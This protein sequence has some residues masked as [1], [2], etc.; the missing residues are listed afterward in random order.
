[1]ST[2]NERQLLYCEFCGKECYSRNSLL[3]HQRRCRYNPNQLVS[4]GAF[5][6]GATAWNKGLTK[7]TD[8][9]VAAHSE[10]V[11]QTK[12][13]KP[14]VNCG[15]AS[16]PEKEFERRAKIAAYAKTR[17]LGGL[18]PK[19]GRGKKGW[20]KGYFCDS[21]YELVFVIYNIDNNIFFKRC[22]RSYSYTVDNKEYRY[23]PDF[24]LADGS[25]VEIKGYHTELVDIKLAS[26]ND[27][28]IKILFEKDL[29][30]AFDWVKK[31][32][33]YKYLYDLYE[34]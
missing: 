9:R 12:K 21:T 30:Y 24:E 19:A 18:T 2:Y 13:N 16:T 33:S 28:P 15:R 23:H 32:Y 8:K 4:S 27:R 29:K 3:N 31:H 14:Q 20:Y 34:S 25:L 22:D 17:G 5:Q 10:Q 1:M 26:V 11:K 7:E 6:K